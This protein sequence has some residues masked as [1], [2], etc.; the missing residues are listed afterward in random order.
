MSDPKFEFKFNRFTRIYTFGEKVEV[1]MTVK[2]E[3]VIKPKEVS[4]AFYNVLTMDSNGHKYTS[5]DKLIDHTQEN[6]IYS[7]PIFIKEFPRTIEDGY[8]IQF[9]F[10]IPEDIPKMRESF[11]GHHISNDY[12]IE[13]IIKRGVFSSNIMTCKHIFVLSKPVPIPDGIPVDI[14]LDSL[15]K[16]KNGDAAARFKG[17]CHLDNDVVTTKNPPKGYIEIFE[18]D[19]PIDFIYVSYGLNE[20]FKRDNVVINSFNTEKNRIHIADDDPPLNTKFPFFLEWSKLNMCPPV[21]NSAFDYTINFSIRIAFFNGA[22]FSNSY[23][24]KIYRD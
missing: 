4:L 14:K 12:F 3:E 18:A 5:Y 2:T 19:T 9:S 13:F 6:E 21:S 11:R 7:Q 22:F 10:V 17:I 23:P 15:C 8:E 24:I 1:T 16:S 20:V